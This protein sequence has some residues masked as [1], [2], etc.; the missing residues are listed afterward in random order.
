[1]KNPQ[2]TI[3]PTFLTHII[4]AIDGVMHLLFMLFAINLFGPKRLQF[5]PYF[6]SQ[7]NLQMIL[8]MCLL[9]NQLSPTSAQVVLIADN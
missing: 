5:K 2:T 1:M 6:C 3:A 7:L 9:L 8:C 4:S